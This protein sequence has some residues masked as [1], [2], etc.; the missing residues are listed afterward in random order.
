MLP[1]LDGSGGRLVFTFIRIKASVDDT[2]SYKVQ[3]TTSL[4]DAGA[5]GESGI[6]LK[7]ALDQVSQADLPD[8]RAFGASKYER[9]EASADTAISAEPSGRQFIRLVVEKN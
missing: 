5:W 3:L 9:I 8:G 4:A 6:T 7:G 1:S 2:L